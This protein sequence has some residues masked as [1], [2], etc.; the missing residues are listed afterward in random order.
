MMQIGSLQSVA[1]IKL[2]GGVGLMGSGE[3]PTSGWNNFFQQDPMDARIINFISE[4]PTGIV[5]QVVTPFVVR[6]SLDASFLPGPVQVRL[7]RDGQVFVENVP[8]AEPSSPFEAISAK[9]FEPA[10]VHSAP[11]QSVFADLSAPGLQQLQQSRSVFERTLGS[12]DI[13][14][15]CGCDIDGFNITCRDRRLTA[16][17]VVSTATA[18]DIPRAVE[19]CLQAAAAAAALA[20]LVPLLITGGAALAAA[21]STFLAVLKPC[22]AG[23][24]ANLVDVRIDI[25]ERCV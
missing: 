23:K 19:E 4:P 9:L 22:L 13:P 24:L 11:M 3:N 5:L 17:L 8:V 7:R 20:A 6:K 16:V 12:A 15:G 10:M 2:R 14:L 21:Q 25:R 1:A 18:D